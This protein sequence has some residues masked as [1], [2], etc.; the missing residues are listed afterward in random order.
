MTPNLALHY[1]GSGINGPVGYGWSVQGISLISR[2]PGD[3]RIDGKAQAVAYN[4]NDKLCLDGQRL[5]QTDAS[6]NPLASQQGDSLGGSGAVREYRTDKDIYSRIRAYGAN[7]NAANGP[8]YFK[9]WTKSGQ[10]YEYGNGG[11]A[12]I[13][14]TGKSIV[15]AWA[16]NRIS[17]TVGNYI[18]FRYLQRDVA[19]GTGPTAG[20]ASAG[21]EWQIKEV[22]YTG[23]AT[24]QAVNRV[25]FNYSDRPAAAAGSAQDRVETYHQGGKNVSIWL[26][27]SISTFINWPADQATRP[28]TAINVKTTSLT[29]DRGPLTNRSRVQ[30]ITEC[31]GDA[32]NKCL[33]PTTFTYSPGDAL[34]YSANEAFKAGPLATTVLHSLAGDYGVLQADFNG[35]GKLDIL[36]W[37]DRPAENQLYLSGATAGQYSLANNFNIR[38]QNLFKSDGCYTTILTDINGDGLPDLL[39]YSA[40]TNLS[41]STCGSYGPIYTYLNNGDGSF[42]RRDF[43]T[44]ISMARK[45]SKPRPVCIKIG[46]CDDEGT[47]HPGWSEGS[48]FYFIDVDGDGRLDI[49]TTILP[50]YSTVADE[51]DPCEA[52]ECTKIY[53]SQ[54][55]GTFSQIATNLA[56]VSVYVQPLAS[57]GVGASQRLMDVNRDGLADL[58]WLPTKYFNKFPFFLSRGDG[59]FDGVA[60]PALSDNCELK[61]DANGDGLQDCLMPGGNAVNNKLFITNGGSGSFFTANFNLTVP[62][63]EMTAA[64]LAG[65]QIA[66]L[67]G[68][69]RD[70]ILRWRDNPALNTVYLSNGDGQFRTASFN[71]TSANNQ[72]GKSDGT[73]TF[74]LGDFIGVG[75][76]QILRLKASPTAGDGTAN[77]LYVKSKGAPPDQLVSVRSGSGITTTLTWVQLT[78]SI[79]GSLGQ[80][81]KSDRGTP[82]AAVYPTIDILPPAYVV[83]TSSA[84]SGFSGALQVSEYAYAGMKWSSD[85]RGWLGFR[86]N[87][88]QTTAPNGELLTVSTYNIQNGPNPGPAS[89]TETRLGALN[90]PGAPL[91]SRSTFIYCDKTAAADAQAAA[92]S[93]T[94]CATTSKVQRPYLYQSTEEGW[95]L[96]GT[97][98][99]KITTT[100]VFN[101]DGDA[102]DIVVVTS[103]TS[104]PAQSSTK[105]TTNEYHAAAIDGDSWILG[106]LKKATVFNDVS[107]SSLSLPT[108][109]GAAPL[110]TANVGTGSE[111]AVTPLVPSINPAVL[112]QIIMLLLGD[113]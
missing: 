59:N 97:G 62:G 45:A 83:A 65:I 27:D 44:N 78:D 49:I 13:T 104:G 46:V 108:S 79:S 43:P 86:T 90:Q 26:L 17:D 110:A 21:H 5:V 50:F 75:D 23:T 99:P 29:Y 31:V 35:D 94:P 28:A 74:I 6:G 71:L 113:D 2:C 20:T 58:R 18:D 4:G 9:V 10:V 38:D 30:K 60:A 47:S 77:Q 34:N 33:P 42:S 105:R 52:M 101:N 82:N 87:L 12:A 25:V 70:D 81:Y 15:S 84:D 7:G 51:V 80:R 88:S 56:N 19:W 103:S 93:S 37:S 41:G 40:S 53:R 3:K 63:N 48:N 89:V 68:D 106:R 61:L 92:T 22:L 32:G 102:T 69:G 100:N 72:L 67:D 55:D 1:S 95:D 57:D 111:P 107:N 16:V 66:D 91:L 8:A 98:L 11:N 24:Q 76:A 39:R 109:A 54:G 73:A 85:G 96:Q 112:N 14:V 36:R 64:S